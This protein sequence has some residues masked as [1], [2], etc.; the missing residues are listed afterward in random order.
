[1]VEASEV[2]TDADLADPSRVMR[3]YLNL[4][5]V[6]P[7]PPPGS[8]LLGL[9]LS[10]TLASTPLGVS[11]LSW[12]YEVL[13]ESATDPAEL[14]A[15]EI[16]ELGWILE[17][18]AESDRTL[19]GVARNGVRY[20]YVASVGAWGTLTVETLVL[21][22]GLAQIQVV[23]R[24]LQHVGPVQVNTLAPVLRWTDTLPAPPGSAIRSLTVSGSYDPSSQNRIRSHATVSVSVPDQNLQEVVSGT[25]R[26]TPPGLKVVSVSES[27]SSVSLRLQDRLGS[28]ASVEVVASG[29]EVLVEWRIP[30]DQP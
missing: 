8:T 15:A 13:V 2:F 7:S 3:S 20:E 5:A 14:L 18:T 29:S 26:G 27:E 25:I 4:P 6:V 23:S 9:G 12:N 19:G 10:A 16:S 21:D 28:P 22:D 1:M 17:T 11:L 24:S 30:L